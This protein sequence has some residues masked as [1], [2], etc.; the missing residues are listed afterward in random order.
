M[1]GKVRRQGDVLLT[2]SQHEHAGGEGQA[3]G[4]VLCVSVLREKAAVGEQRV[5]ED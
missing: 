2:I 1:R 4:P 5:K 3:Q